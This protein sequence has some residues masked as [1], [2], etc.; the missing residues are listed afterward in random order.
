MLMERDSQ[1]YLVGKMDDTVSFYKLYTLVI[2]WEICMKL[3]VLATAINPFS[4][5]WSV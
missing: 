3:F 5:V 2:I 1:L 4:K